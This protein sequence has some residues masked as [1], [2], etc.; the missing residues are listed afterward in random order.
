MEHQLPVCICELVC[1]IVHLCVCG[2]VSVPERPVDLQELYVDV[3]MYLNIS[4][5]VCSVICVF[6]RTL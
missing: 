3:L 1:L 6:L 2:C 5:L 4:A